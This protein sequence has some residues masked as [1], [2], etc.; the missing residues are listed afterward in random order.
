MTAE[1][2]EMDLGGSDGNTARYDD[3]NGSDASS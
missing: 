2:V 1:K 3:A